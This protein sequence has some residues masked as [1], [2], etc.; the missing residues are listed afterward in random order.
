MQD[1]DNDMS[2][3]TRIELLRRAHEAR[4]TLGSMAEED[5]IEVIY[6]LERVRGYARP[7][8]IASILGVK[9]ASVT[10]MIKRLEKKNYIV[11]ER[12]RSVRLTEKGRELAQKIARNHSFLLEFLESLGVSR[13]KANI[14]AELLEH[15]L[16]EETI[17]RL[18]QFYME[19]ANRR[20]RSSES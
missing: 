4:K 12:Y 15:F 8:D 1:N 6:E 10:S 3:Q 18:R 9:A 20:A 13:E 2:G 14:E 16:S 17:S 19:C 11:Y 5:Y 7:V